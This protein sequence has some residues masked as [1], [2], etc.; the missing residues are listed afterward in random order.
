M[1]SEQ[2]Q[3]VSERMV[4]MEEM[5]LDLRQTIAEGSMLKGYYLRDAK[6]VNHEKVQTKMYFIEITA[7]TAKEELQA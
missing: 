5:L 2:L 4:A 6:D 1:T 3:K 7:R